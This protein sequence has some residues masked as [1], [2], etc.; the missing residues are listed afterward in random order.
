MPVAQSLKDKAQLLCVVNVSLP[1]QCI[2]C[3]INLKE[4]TSKMCNWRNEKKGV[5]LGRVIGA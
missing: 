3:P 2:E 5:R 1:L 4:K